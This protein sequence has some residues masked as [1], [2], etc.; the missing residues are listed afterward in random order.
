MPGEKQMLNFN[1][2][3]LPKPVQ[4]EQGAKPPQ[5]VLSVILDKVFDAGFLVPYL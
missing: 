5:T 3:E 4:K 2:P 1:I